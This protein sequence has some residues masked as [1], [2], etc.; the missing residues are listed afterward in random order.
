MIASL[1]QFENRVKWQ[2]DRIYRTRNAIV[3]SGNAPGYLGSL[4]TN[5]FE[6]FRI[7][8]QEILRQ[9]ATSS[10]NE[11]IS[12]SLEEIGFTYQLLKKRV[13]LAEKTGTYSSDDVGMLFARIS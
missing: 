8:A 10:S 1:N 3:H 13:G 6:T 11:D 7:S 5:I 9:A 4:T 12:Q 2:I